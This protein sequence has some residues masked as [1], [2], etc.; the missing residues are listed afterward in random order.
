MKTKNSNLKVTDVV[1]NYTGEGWVYSNIVKKH[2]FHPYNFLLKDPKPDEFDARGQVGSPQC[3]DV[4]K[5]WIKVDPKTKKIKK[6]KWRTFGCASAIAATSMF[7]VMAT[8]KGGMK[9]EEA[10]KIRPQ[11]IMERLGGL[12]AR[13][14]HCSV[15]CDKAFQ[16]AANNYFRTTSQFKKI[17]TEGS[18]VVDKRL[19]ITE[20]DIEQSVLE[21]AKTLV[22]VQKKLKVGVGDP[23]AIPEIEQLIRF[24]LEKYYG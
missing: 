5:M 1:S 7:S 24:Y 18:K 9:V 19:N 16:Q 4:M 15:L 13:K 14:V 20:R 11:D 6:L 3:G 22:D 21:G 10:L 2:F 12:P 8:E 23:K 17:I